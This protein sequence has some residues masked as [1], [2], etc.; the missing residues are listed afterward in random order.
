GVKQAMIENNEHHD[1][2]NTAGRETFLNTGRSLKTNGRL[3]H[4]AQAKEDEDEDEEPVD[5]TQ[6]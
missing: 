1:Q 6:D 3:L 5:N 4:K 2:K